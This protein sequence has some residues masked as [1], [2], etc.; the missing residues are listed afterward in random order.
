VADA[1]G[2]MYLAA[3]YTYGT[4]EATVIRLKPNGALDTS[5]AGGG[6]AHPCTSSSGGWVTMWKTMPTVVGYVD[7]STDFDDLFARFVA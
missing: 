3:T 5:F 4:A 7:L 1:T 6:F 2:R